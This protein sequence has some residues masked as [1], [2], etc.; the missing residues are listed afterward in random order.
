MK[1]QKAWLPPF[2]ILA[3]Q[4]VFFAFLFYADNKYQTPPPYGKYGIIAVRGEDLERGN[5]IFLIDG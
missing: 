1:W 4:A 2:A 5:P 3:L